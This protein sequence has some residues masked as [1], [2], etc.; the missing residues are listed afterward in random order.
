[1]SLRKERL[2][3]EQQRQLNQ[4]RQHELSRNRK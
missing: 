1:M 2:L 4:R 3:E